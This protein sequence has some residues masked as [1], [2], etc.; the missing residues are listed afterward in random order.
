[1][2]E[3][4]L[5]RERRETLEEFLHGPKNDDDD[6]SEESLP[7][8]VESAR[9]E[10]PP[11]L[12]P[13]QDIGNPSTKRAF[14][15]LAAC[16]HIDFATSYDIL[17]FAYDLNL[18]TSIGSKRNLRGKNIPLRLMLKN[19]SFSP[20]KW[21]NAHLALL[22][23]VRQRGY[24]KMFLTIAPYEWSMPYHISILDAMKKQ[25]KP[26]L[27]Y[28]IWETLHQTHVLHEI[29]WGLIAG[30][31]PEYNKI[32]KGRENHQIIPPVDED[33]KKIDVV[34]VLRT[35]FQDG[36]RKEAT[37]DYHGSGRPHTHALLFTDEPEKL[38]LHMWA[39]ATLPGR[40]QEVLRGCVQG[41]QDDRKCETPWPTHESES[42]WDPHKMTYQLKHTADDHANGRRAYIVDVMDALRCHQDLQFDCEGG[43][44]R[45]YLTKYVPKF[46]DSITDDILDDEAELGGDAT[47]AGVLAKYKPLEPEMILQLHAARF[48][49]F[50]VNTASRGM[51][52][53]QVPFPAQE[54]KK[55]DEFMSI[56]A[57]EDCEWRS[58]R[59]SLLEFLRKTSTE[60][61]I[62]P[63]VKSAF[64]HTKTEYVSL[65]DF[66]NTCGMRGEKLICCDMRSRFNDVFY[67]QWLILHV[68]FRKMTDFI[69][70]DILDK[71]PEAHINF[72]FAYLC[73]DVIAKNFWCDDE[74]IRSEMQMQGDNRYFISE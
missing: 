12:N 19:E 56:K 71:V 15:V 46:S 64:E 54:R 55:S 6:S 37:Q 28:P 3:T 8:L 5:V 39:S 38:K 53:F 21:N 33:G 31:N 63:W 40:D 18:W 34:M 59:M 49:Q 45:A 62:L 10:P 25:G 11:R 41:S 66:A 2:S 67:G 69:Q 1:M 72:A 7:D 14:A 42:C 57:Y 48:R 13:D 50:R 35:E 68:P 61:N 74:A 22:D 27:R 16:P 23:L 65:E 30:L 73:T 52:E 32:R 51:R 70:Q 44:L 24:P 47:A 9:I 4:R 20:M 26:R 29:N 17:H 43:A 58:E 36:T 60:G